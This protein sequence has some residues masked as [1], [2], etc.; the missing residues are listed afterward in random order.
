MT[1]T[2]WA[3]GNDCKLNWRWV[4]FSH[5][6]KHSVTKWA[7]DRW[8]SGNKRWYVTRMLEDRKNCGF[9]QEPWWPNKSCQSEVITRE[10]V[11]SAIK[12]A[13]SN[14]GFKQWPRKESERRPTE[15]SPDPQETFRS[16]KCFTCYTVDKRSVVK[17]SIPRIYIQK[18]LNSCS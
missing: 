12:S 11:K 13:L 9:V 7:S 2:Y 5:Q 4:E 1:N 14:R 15:E 6:V 10:S 16:I 18:H 8:Y 17:E 3:Y